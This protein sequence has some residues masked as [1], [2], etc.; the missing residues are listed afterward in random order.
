M[1]KARKMVSE[2]Y[3]PSFEPRWRKDALRAY[4]TVEG[5]GARMGT[6]TEDEV[7]EL[8]KGACDLHI[9]CW[10][11]P[12]IDTGWSQSHIA[13]RATDEGMRAVL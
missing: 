5:M 11:H 2:D 10:H 3:E 8:M 12:L 1:A 13:K 4:H 7:G 9:H 6:I